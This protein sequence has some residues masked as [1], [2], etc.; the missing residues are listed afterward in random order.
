MI[1]FKTN[2][3]DNIDFL[4]VTIILFTACNL[5]CKFCFQKHANDIDYNDIINIKSISN[6]IIKKLE[7]NHKIK[8]VSL[9]FM[10]GQLFMDSISDNIFEAYKLG[11][12]DPIPFSAEHGLGLDDLYTSLLEKIK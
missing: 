11:L 2:F 1:N 8:Q 3:Y 12:G 7:H 9:H 5:N 4:Q 10:G 6:E